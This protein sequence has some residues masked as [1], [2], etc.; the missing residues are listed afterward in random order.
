MSVPSDPLFAGFWGKLPARGDFIGHGLPAAWMQAWEPWLM[1][2]LAEVAARGRPLAD[3]LAALPVWGF[4]VPVRPGSLWACGVLAPSHD[5][6]GRAFPLVLVEGRAGAS[7]GPSGAVCDRV[8]ALAALLPLARRDDAPARLGP[9]LH[10]LPAVSPEW[11]PAAPDSAAWW[12]LDRPATPL[13]C[14]WPAD[15]G[16]FA[17]CLLPG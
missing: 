15:R 8:A 11:G 9:A 6:V 17:R 4:V 7:P 12:R 14:D 10:A 2:G 5:R 16:F 13:P 3:A 1:E